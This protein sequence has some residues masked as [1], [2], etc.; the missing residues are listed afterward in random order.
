M[1]NFLPSPLVGAITIVLL[2]CNVLFW[3]G[4]LLAFAVVKLLIPINAV[5]KVFNIILIKLAQGWVLCNSGWMRLTQDTKWDVQGLENLNTKGWYLV[6]SNHQS[7]V[8]ILVLQRI[9]NGK[10]PF[11]KFFLKQEL[12]HVPIMGL[13]WWALDFPFMKRFSKSYLEKHPEMRG[14]DLET[15]RIACEK[16]SQMPTSVINFLEGTRLTESKHEKQQ[17][18]YRY[19]LKPK[20]GGIAFALNAMGDKFQSLL[21]ITIAYPD[22]TPTFMDFLCGRVKN[23][24]VRVERVPI[25]KHFCEKDYNSDP[26]FKHEIQLWTHNMWLRKDDLLHELLSAKPQKPL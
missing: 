26:E 13:C 7:W 15:T 8:D 20:A 22:G 16:F 4:W 9:F 14:K 21:N 19:L 24:I 18:P 5:R 10:I 11:L 6:S 12:I 2:A 25:P 17:S 3:C 1:L 23:I